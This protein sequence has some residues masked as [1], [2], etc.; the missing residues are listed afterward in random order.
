MCLKISVTDAE[1]FIWIL[2]TSRGNSILWPANWRDKVL[3]FKVNRQGLGGRSAGVRNSAGINLMRV[4]K[5]WKVMYLLHSRMEIL[6]CP[7]EV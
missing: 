6:C 4:V 5:G 2:E 7:G 3:A 1:A